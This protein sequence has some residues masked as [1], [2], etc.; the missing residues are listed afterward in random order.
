M[1]DGE[2]T[3]EKAAMGSVEKY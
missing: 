3:E 1:I 2:K